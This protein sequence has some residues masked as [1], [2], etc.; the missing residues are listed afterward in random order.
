MHV[1]GGGMCVG[2]GACGGGGMWG[3]GACGG[4]WGH[5]FG[6]VVSINA[7]CTGLTDCT[8]YPSP[9]P[10][11]HCLFLKIIFYHHH[12]NQV[13]DC[14]FVYGKGRG[15]GA[16]GTTVDYFQSKPFLRFRHK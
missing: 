11:V 16:A 7:G 13:L 6:G 5:V 10:K 12:H 3:W 8:K 4:G 15:R 1:G 14:R 9:P 2:V